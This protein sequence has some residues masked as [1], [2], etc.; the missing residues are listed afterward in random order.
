VTRTDGELAAYRQGALDVV[1]AIAAGLEHLAAVFD[2]SDP[3]AADQ[4]RNAATTV[5]MMRSAVDVVTSSGQQLLDVDQ[6]GLDTWL[7]AQQ[8]QQRGAG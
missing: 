4:A 8:Q 5:R 1:E 6:A 3:V 2:R 7:L